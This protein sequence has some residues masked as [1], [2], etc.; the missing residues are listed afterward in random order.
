[1]IELASG[2][3]LT[4]I[5]VVSSLII[6]NLAQAESEGFAQ[7]QY[8][9]SQLDAEKIQKQ[10]QQDNADMMRNQKLE[11]EQ[12]YAKSISD[13]RREQ[14]RY[15]AQKRATVVGTFFKTRR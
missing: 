11:N 6:S 10:A 2:L 5:G 14:S 15:E 12:S 4:G 13:S 8:K 1:M 3:L 9:Q 7:Q